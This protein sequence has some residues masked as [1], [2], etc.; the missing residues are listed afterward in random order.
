MVERQGLDPALVNGVDPGRLVIGAG[1]DATIVFKDEVAAFQNA[2]GVYL[3]APDGTIHDPRVL[4]ARIEAAVADPRFPFARPGGGPLHA[5]DAVRLSELYSAEQLA[6][7]TQFGLFLIANGAAP[8]RGQAELLGG[9]GR[10]ELVSRAT[11]GPASIFAPAADLAL[12]HTA[13]DGTVRAVRGDLLH[14][15]DPSPG[16]PLANPLNPDG[17]GHVVAQDDPTTGGLLIGFED[18]RDFD[19]NDVLVAVVPTPSPLNEII[20]SEADDLL[21]GTAGADRIEGLA[22]DDQL[23]GL[24]GDDV[25]LGGP[26]ADTLIGDDPVAL[27]TATAS[28]FAT[29]PASGQELALTLTTPASAGGSEVDLSGLITLG[30]HFGAA[31]NVALVV[32]VSGSMAADFIGQSEIG[33]VNGDGLANTRLDAMITGLEGLVQGLDASGFG[34]SVEVGLIPFGTDATLAATLAASADLDGDGTLDLSQLLRTLQLDGGTDY[35]RAFD[36]TVGFFDGQPAA[37][38]LV[39][40]VS[41]G[42]GFGDFQHDLALL[43]DP[44]GLDATIAAFGIGADV[45]LEQLGQIDS[46]GAPA[47]VT[48]PEELAAALPAAPLP[49]AAIAQID[50]LLDGTPVQTLGPDDLQPTPLGLAYH[51]TI[52]GLTTDSGAANAIEVL[53]TPTGDPGVTLTVQQEILGAGSGAD[54]LIGGPGPDVLV[55]GGGPDAFVFQSADDGVDRILDFDAR[56]GDFLDLSEVLRGA[57]PAALDEQVI[58]SAVDADG[59]WPC[60]RHSARGRSRRRR[61]WRARRA[62]G[63]GRSGRS[64]GRRERPGPRRRRHR[65]GLRPELQVDHDP[66]PD[67]AAD[68]LAGEAGQ[69]RER[70][71]LDHA[72]EQAEIEVP[73]QALPGGPAGRRRLVDRNRSRAG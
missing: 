1:R 28:A 68:N 22:G 2:L 8:G 46:A 39:Y 72:F 30:S 11:G 14:T 50:V 59:D 49:A 43:A 29:L 37:T 56:A 36:A 60:R 67:L 44:D 15:A 21:I 33:D 73:R 25:L 5:G 10:L 23:I 64:R 57:G 6:P 41:D 17:L 61:S 54:R 16:D 58:L 45:S 40:F 53:M 65:R 63:A 70:R 19:F 51:T 31:F 13:P 18:G 66:A 42:R 27:G 55:G 35:G 12:L 34:H 32:D 20:G 24:G 71:R 9:D 3:I 47:L 52:G 38:N 48:T 26:G 4:F 7:G 69:I 62:R